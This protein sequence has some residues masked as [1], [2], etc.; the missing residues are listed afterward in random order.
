ML[1]EFGAFVIETTRGTDP[2]SGYFFPPCAGDLLPKADF[3]DSPREEYRGGDEAFGPLQNDFRESS[4]WSH[5]Y[6]TL[7]RPGAEVARLIMM[8]GFK[9]GTRATVDA[10]GKKG[11]LYPERNSFIAGG[12][13]SGKGL[14]YI[15][16]VIAKDGNTYS[17]YHGGGIVKGWTLESKRPSDAKIS[18]D[19]TGG[20]FIGAA[21]QAATTGYSEPTLNPFNSVEVGLYYG[22]TGVTRTGSAPDFTDIAV[23]TGTATRVK[24]EGLSL[25]YESGLTLK[26]IDDG[27]R[28]AAK[29]ERDKETSW[30]LSF[31]TDLDD[32]AGAFAAHTLY[33]AMQSGAQYSPF[34]IE[35]KLGVL[36][37]AATE[38]YR[39]LIDLPLGMIT[40][41]PKSFRKGKPAQV[42]FKV[43]SRLDLTIGYVLGVLTV[44]R[45]ATY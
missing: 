37:G 21:G 31:T 38:Y 34:V 18:F 44:D 42:T 45:S 40:A 32:P 5:G 22:A 13:L 43:V 20:P 25:K 27:Y 2:G 3:K 24:H 4:E 35:A 8:S 16:N 11:I 30:E 39:T 12:S 36:A 23:N 28:G 29:V 10:T 14:G 17:R 41:E 6:P 15:P 7:L 26:D 19:I 1:K 33:A 9:A